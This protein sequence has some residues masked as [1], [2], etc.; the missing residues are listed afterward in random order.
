MKKAILPYLLVFTAV[1][2]VFISSRFVLFK[3][4]HGTDDLHYAMLAAKMLKGTYDPFQPGD[5]F[6]GRIIV[7]A[8][9]AF[10]YR[11]G[12]I[13]VFM[14]STGTVAATVAACLI[15]VTKLLPVRTP[16]TTLVACC[17]FYFSPPLTNDI[18]GISPDP[19]ILLVST[20]I[21]LI[22]KNDSQEK[23]P[24]HHSW[25]RA[26][27][28]GVLIAVTL[29]IK[30]TIII[31]LP[32]S[33]LMIWLYHKKLN[34]LWVFVSSLAMVVLMGWGYHHFTG[35]AF[36]KFSQI[37]NSAY[38]NPCNFSYLP[39]KDLLIRLT[40]GTW[41]AFTLLGFYPFVLGGI[42]LL[43][44]FLSGKKIQ[45][46][47]EYNLTSFILLLV[48]SLYLPFSWKSYQPLCAA[49]RH[50][51][52]LLPSAVILVTT[53]LHSLP[54]T[55]RSWSVVTLLSFV[56]LIVCFSGTSNKWQWM[57][58]SMLFAYFAGLPVL[59]RLAGNYHYAA[60]CCILFISI[61]EPLFFN[62]TDWFANMRG[63]SKTIYTGYY[64]FPDHDNLMHWKLLHHFDDSTIHAYNI[65]KHP[66]KVYQV[67]YQ[68]MDSTRFHPGWLMVNKAYTT[69]SPVFLNRIDSLQRT[70]YFSD[71]VIKGA[72]GAFWIN[73]KEQYEYIR[74]INFRK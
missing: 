39:L 22:L 60:F 23:A 34:S 17:L 3:S 49:P 38:P 62:R 70:K 43:A 10:L 44:P 19:Y 67:Y 20:C 33:M 47:K 68:K 37:E 31:F 32:Y 54:D 6:S 57:I 14:T 42:A 53:T 21:L 52:F 4:F 24:L 72:L 27:V 55:R 74:S 36:F 12:G 66:Y 45:W 46:K 5:I 56:L 69:C 2:A 50:F 71:Y 61:L 8:W 11:I 15:T 51:Y 1:T 9:Q 13:N 63:I 40:Y 64:Y 16:A 18:P 26:V 41:R 25:L 28:M 48:L 30:E 65:E 7:I 73:S 35:N 59:K 29:L 58:Y